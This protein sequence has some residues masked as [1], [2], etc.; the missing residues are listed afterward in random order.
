MT[1]SD[2]AYAAILGATAQIEWKVLEPHF[3]RGDLLAV[4]AALD[5]VQVAAAMMEDNSEAIKGWMD[6]GQLQ[7]ATDS[8]AADW[9]ARNPDTLWAVV[10]RP[11]VLVQERIG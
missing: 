4:D 3:A 6:A 10:I 8:C 2:E 11:W 1:V 5:L 9:A 7:V